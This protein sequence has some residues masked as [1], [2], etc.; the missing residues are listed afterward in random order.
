MSTIN[1]SSFAELKTAVEDTTSTEINILN[2]ITFS[3]GIKINVAKSETIIN[4]NNHNDINDLSEE[5]SG[6]TNPNANLE[7]SMIQFQ[8]HQHLMML[9]ISIF[10]YLTKSKLKHR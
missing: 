8:K 10:Y 1:V 5:V 6:T 9:E 4:F 7:L 3:G 2:D